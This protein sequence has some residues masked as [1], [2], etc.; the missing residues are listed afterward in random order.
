MKKFLL[1][2]ILSVFTLSCTSAQQQQVSQ[3]PAAAEITFTFT[4][5][6]RSASN[7]YAVWIENAQGQHVKT[8]YATRW[9]AAGGFR[10]RPSS[11]PIWVKIF[12]LIN[13]SRDQID[14]VSSPTPRTGTVTYT[15]DGTDA[16]GVLAANGSYVL[17][18]EGTLR[19][20]N[21][22]LY[23]APFSLGQ[24]TSGQSASTP[25]VSVQYTGDSTAERS[26]IG[27]VVVKV[28]R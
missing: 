13:A 25:H 21:Q 12:N 19:W 24:L 23:R 9:T 7:Q 15:W 20:E 28:M 22:V 8:L 3:Y 27:G 6:T 16:R 14:A 4:R 17:V 2:F 1:I 10:S 11:I 5:Q 26:M 18:L